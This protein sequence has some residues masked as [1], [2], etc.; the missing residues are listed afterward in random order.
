[1]SFFI[2]VHFWRTIAIRTNQVIFI[3]HDKRYFSR[4]EMEGVL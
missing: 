1:M 4:F 2:S 3:N